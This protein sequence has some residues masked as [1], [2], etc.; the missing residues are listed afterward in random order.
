MARPLGYRQG[1][2]IGGTPPAGPAPDLEHWMG[3]PRADL[4]AECDAIRAQRQ[5]PDPI[6]AALFDDMAT[7]ADRASTLSCATRRSYGIATCGRCTSCQRPD[8]G[9]PS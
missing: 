2:R 3:R 9:A 1:R 5:L 4:A 6:L 8:Q 7:M